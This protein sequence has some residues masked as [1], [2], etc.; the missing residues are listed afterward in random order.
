MAN[1]VRNDI[2][3]L[4]ENLQVVLDAIGFNTTF[5]T[6][7]P[8]LGGFTVL[9]NFDRI[10]PRPQDNPPE[11]W[12][13]WFSDNWGTCPYDCALPKDILEQSDNKI[14]FSVY[15]KW[16]TAYTSL[17]KVVARFPNYKYNLYMRELANHTVGEVTWVNGRRRL[18]VQTYRLL[19]RDDGDYP[20][21]PPITE[22]DK[23]KA[24]E[25]VRAA[26]QTFQ[27]VIPDED[28]EIVVAEIL[29][30]GGEAALKV[31]F[32]SNDDGSCCL[33]VDSGL[34]LAKDVEE[35]K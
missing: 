4:G 12:S 2:T 33:C 19:L 27:G 7:V 26:A 32:V 1:L 6:R 10:V 28:A 23:A 16:T 9:F 8:K 22:A 18:V 20:A 21:F 31:Q 25:L 24:A 34:R 29:A 35:L 13:K 3:I 15:T 14:C 11:G 5:D 17:E 30:N